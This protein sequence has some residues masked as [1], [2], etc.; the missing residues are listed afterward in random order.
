M[1]STYEEAADPDALHSTP[2][3]AGTPN[4]HEAGPE[5]GDSA[6][7]Q[8][9]GGQSSTDTDQERQP[10]PWA[11]YARLF[12]EPE[13]GEGG[14]AA[15]V[16]LGSLAAGW[17]LSRLIRPRPVNW[18]RAV[19]AGV[20]GTA[21]AELAQTLSH[22]G[23]ERPLPFPPRAEDLPRY[24]AGVATAAAYASQIYPRLP[25]SPLTRGL[26][27]GTVEAMVAESG[28]TFGLLQRV[29]PELRLPLGPLGPLS[30]LSTQ[31]VPQ[32]GA[33]GSLAFGLGLGLYS[34]KGKRR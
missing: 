28:G 24:A 31:M 13:S 23:P 8:T 21:L 30:P 6:T 25:G 5:L 12:T 26:I 16:A 4:D 3:P 15:A 11:G 10:S 1:A 14:T 32:R 34:A 29:A 19:L 9:A 22:R 2:Y 33:L 7:R 27:F 17:V 18:P 20:A